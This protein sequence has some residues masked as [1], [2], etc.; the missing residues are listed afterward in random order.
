M[1]RYSRGFLSVAQL[2]SQTGQ[3]N[4]L[5][6]VQLEFHFLTVFSARDPLGAFTHLAHFYWNVHWQAR[7]QPANFTNLALPW[8]VQLVP[9]GNARNIGPVQHGI[10]NPT[11]ARERAMV[12][13]LSS[14]TLVN[15]CNDIAGT[16]ANAVD[17]VADT[18]AP[19]APPAIAP[20]ANRRESKVWANFVVTR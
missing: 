18:P 8:H 14:P 5:R 2:N 9:G 13:A 1:E 6:E 10:P 20:N 12:A 4:F 7:F 19:L 3:I 15:N 16:A 11:N 17:P